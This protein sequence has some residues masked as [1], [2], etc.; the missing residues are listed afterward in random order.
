MA[1]DHNQANEYLNKLG[2]TDNREK[3]RERLL[4]KKNSDLTQAKRVPRNPH[5]NAESVIQRWE[6]IDAESVP[7]PALL[8]DRTR[9]EMDCYERNIENFIGTLK[10]P[11]GIA[12]P[13]RVNGLHAQGDYYIP[14]ATTEA[15][16][17]A[18]Y[19]RG[20]QLISRA[21]GATSMVLSQGVSRAP[22]F[23]FKSIVDAGEF[24]AWLSP[25]FETFKEIAAKT[26]AHGSLTDIRVTLE[27]NHVYVGFTYTTGDAAGQN[28]VTIATNEVYTYIL[29]Q[30]PVKPEYSFLEANLSGDKKASALSFLSVRGK[31]VT[32]EVVLSE[33]LVKRMLHTTP[34]RMTDYWRMSAMG[35]VLS[36]TIGVQGHYANGLA[37]LYIACGQDAA[38]V[39]ESS[40]GV[41]RFELLEDNSL[42]A[43]VT[44][45]NLIVG[46]V[47]GGTGLPSQKACL[48]IMQLAGQ[49]KAMA[50]AEVCAT[51]CL[52]GELSIIGALCAGHFS[53]AHQQLARG[54]DVNTKNDDN[55]K[56]DSRDNDRSD[57]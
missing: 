26:T 42:Y 45:P 12:G 43:S 10:M 48:D 41:T 18:S 32:T 27:G 24:I 38:C 19:N 16:L 28:M 33:S 51:V 3:L 56:S 30:S 35:G 31:K 8:D 29:A 1:I 47:G 37:A 4:P 21:G 40:V 44:M 54:R 20:A 49:G 57:S 46:T 53:R 36:G 11:V 55:D 14:L 50:F 25:Q 5:V 39:S 15:A 23:A 17:V 7:N 22:G 13:L 52:A 2:A 6:V 34:K 9:Q